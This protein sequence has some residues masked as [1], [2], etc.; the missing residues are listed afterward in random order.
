MNPYDQSN[1]DFIMS[2]SDSE[3]DNWILDL[4]DDDVQYAIE[5]IQQSRANL[6]TQ[7]QELSESLVGESDFTEAREV[8]A[9]FRL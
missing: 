9:R 8:L 4:S 1:L 5:L 2:L 7:E 3:F 6:L